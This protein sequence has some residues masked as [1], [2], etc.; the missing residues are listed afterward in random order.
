MSYSN[1]SEFIYHRYKHISNCVPAICRLFQEYRTCNLSDLEIEGRLGKIIKN[2]N[3]YVFKPG[4][5]E[6]HF[7]RILTQLDSCEDW[8]QVQGWYPETD[9][10]FETEEGTLRARTSYE[11]NVEVSYCYKTKM[12][13]QDLVNQT[14]ADLY[15]VRISL[16]REKKSDFSKEHPELSV[17]APTFVRSKC[18]QTY[19]YNRAGKEDAPIW[20]Y[21][22]C[23][24]WEGKS[25]EEVDAKKTTT[26]PRLEVECEFCNNSN[27]L[28]MHD[29]MYMGTSLLLKCCDLQPTDNDYV[30]DPVCM[31][32]RSHV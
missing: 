20:R 24:V 1:S 14:N 3:S 23:M 12:S 9:Y 7:N 26:K 25:Q 16:N 27:Y 10:M 28:R 2:N 18:K 5:S 31:R 19:Y 32:T 15:D 29:D 22:L 8:L 30:M 11:E 17:M 21:D 13:C 6:K 4:V